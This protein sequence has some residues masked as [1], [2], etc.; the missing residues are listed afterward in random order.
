[1]S[2]TK[3]IVN[4][5]D[6]MLFDLLAG[7]K[8]PYPRTVS[9]EPVS[10][11]CQLKCPLCP[12]GTQKFGHESVIMQLG[13][14]KTLLDKMPF[15]TAIELYKSGEPFLNPDLFA[16]IKYAEDLD[17]KITIS[18]HFSFSKP[19]FFFESIVTSGL[20]KLVVS[21]DGASPE[22][23]SKYRIGG[24]FELVMKNLK[25]L[26]HAKS[27]LG[28]AKPEIVWQ[29][30][31]T[32]FNEHE[33]PLAQK[34]AKDLNIALDLRPFGLSDDAPDVEMDGT[35]QERKAYWL[36]T[37]QSYVSDCYKSDYSYPIYKEMCTRLFTRLVVTAEGK[38]L[39]CCEVWDNNNDFGNL[40]TCS[41][42]DVWYSRKYLEARSRFLKEDF[43]P[44]V[45]SI[46]FRCNNFSTAP[47]LRDK[48]NL[49]MSV[50]RKNIRGNWRR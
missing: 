29:F 33:I 30:L 24:D 17:I 19:E 25:R 27:R 41:F 12:T 43:T 22:S 16:M 20:S 6:A 8:L 35:I 18:S 5:L 45:Q 4:G 39:P 2:I 28:N 15:I 37:D 42:D 1:V 7:R 9:I 38:V 49:L 21:I 50:Y 31:V 46:C 26:L 48:L 3:T 11:L 40:L 44:Q 32:R 13:T 47:S 34:M 23:Y 14:F 10:N 36:P